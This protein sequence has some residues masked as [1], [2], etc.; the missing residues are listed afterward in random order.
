MN[1]KLDISS[2]MNLV[3]E[4]QV[5]NLETY[6]V[7]ILM[8]LANRLK[9][10]KAD[11]SGAK[12]RIAVLGSYSIQHFVSVLD[13]FLYNYGFTTDIYEGE[14][15]G[16]NMDVLDSKSKLYQFQPDIIILMIHDKDIKVLPELLDS[17]ENI[18]QLLRK[19]ID[20]YKN[21]WKCL[22]QIKGC[23]IL[24]TN[25]VIPVHR[26]IGNMSANYVFSERSYLTMLNLELARQRSKNVTIMDMD[27]LA[28]FVG[29]KD[30]FD[31][32]AYFLTKTGFNINYLGN[33]AKLFADEIKVMQGQTKKC[34]VLDLDNTIWG[35]VV[36]DDGCDGI[37]I[38]PHNAIGEAYRY[39]QSYVL[40]LKE[41]GIILAVCSKN[42][43]DIAKLPFQKNEN[44]ILQLSDIACFKAN[45]NNK[46]DNIKMIAK[47]LNIGI[48]SLVFVDDNPA[49][50]EIV[51]TYLPE[52]TV[53]DLPEDPALYA[54]A[55]EEANPFEWM[56]ITKEDLVRSDSYQ[57]NKKRCEMESSFVNYDEYLKALNM[58]AKMGK[59]ESTHVERFAQL[60]NKSNQFNL[61]T[62]R[63]SESQIESMR[64][65]KDISLLYVDLKDKFTT[66]GIISCIIL[67]KINDVCFIDTWL[68]SCRVL[69]RGVENLT[70]QM[71]NQ[72]ADSMGC[73]TIIGE[74]I[75]SKKNGMVKDFYLDLGFKEVKDSKYQTCEESKIYTFQTTKNIEK[76]LF[77]EQI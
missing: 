77:I 35:G 56:E 25:F 76:E 16:I 59:I 68:M 46:A 54:N 48:D 1:Q 33:V 24:Q 12:L 6:D 67:K 22:E 28:S 10:Q 69:K 17:K 62:K 18:S 61:R 23:H 9:K 45:W 11:H 21:L 36:G 31:Y 13:V 74:Y 57:D 73:H 53:I 71:V 38:D 14:Y 3:L 37:Q 2:I 19:Q 70:F 42:E 50:R 51:K 30:W 52:V 26:E 66:Y 40:R 49:E 7:T 41:R 27:Y 15:D 32:S 20:Y 29:K 8:K 75:E 58:Q 47:E 55:L 39:F 65:D 43:E 63:Y 60:I 4:S 64:N 44:M 72:Y 34:L 5:Q